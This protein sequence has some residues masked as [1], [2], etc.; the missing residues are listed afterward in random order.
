[1]KGMTDDCFHASDGGFLPS[2][3]W[4]FDYLT[5]GLPSS[6]VFICDRQLAPTAKL[7]TFHLRI[8]RYQLRLS[9]GQ[10]L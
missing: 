9:D 5:Q 4:Q 2:G 6:I 3:Y 8:A 7:R 10:R 1:M